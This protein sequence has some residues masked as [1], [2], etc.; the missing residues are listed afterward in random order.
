MQQQ[1]APSVIPHLIRIVCTASI[2]LTVQAIQAQKKPLDHSVYDG[3]QSIGERMI[4]SDGKRVAYTVMPQEGDGE[5]IVQQP[6]SGFRKSIARGYNAAFTFDDSFLIGKIKPLFQDTRQAKIKKKKPDEMPKDTLFILA[7]GTDSL[8]KIARVKEYKLP[9]KGK[10]Y[11]AYLLEK[12]LP[13]SSKKRKPSDSLNSRKEGLKAM[14]DS[15]IGKTIDSVKG[16]ITREE[17][18][19][20]L[21][22]TTE[23]ILKKVR[24][25]E[26][27]DAEGD[28]AA[29]K[30]EA[31]GGTLIVRN[32]FTGRDTAFARIK[33]YW[34]DKYG[35]SL[36]LKTSR[37][38]KDS[39]SRSALLL[40]HLAIRRT[41]TL[42]SAINDAR[43]VA[44][45]ESGV[46]VCFAAERDSSEKALTRFYK[47]WYYRHGYDSARLIADKNTPGM[48]I[49]S[50]VSEHGRIFFSK[51]GNRIFFGTAPVQPPKDT[52]LV[53][54]ETARLDIWHHK[55]EY[56]QT[57]QLKNLDAELK[58]SYTAVYHT[59]SGQLVQAGTE[60]TEL[61]SV[62]D[63][64]NSPWVLLQTN[65][66]YRIASQWTGRSRTDASVMNTENGFMLPVFKG[67]YASATA[68]PGGK[69][70]CWY[71]PEK[72]HYFS[73]D[74]SANKTTNITQKINTPLHDEENDVPDFP[75]PYGLM[76]WQAG[77]SFLY[78]YDR[79]DI[80]KVAPDG[81]FAPQR[82]S[83]K[84]S[85][86]QAQSGR[87]KQ[88][89]TRFINTDK[90]FRFF[91]SGKKY[92]FSGFYED[93]KASSLFLS[94]PDMRNPLFVID[95]EP[96]SNG[97][98]LLSANGEG[99]VFSRESYGLSPE[100]YYVNDKNVV[101]GVEK[102]SPRPVLLTRT[103]PQQAGYN[104][105][106]A[107]LFRWTAYNGKA[108]TGILYK[109][110]DYRPGKHYPMICYFYER[111]SDGLHSYQP[112]APTPS[113]LNISFFV[114]RGYMVFVPDIVY[115]KGH[116]GDDAYDYVASGARALVKKGY[117]DSSRIGI[118]GQSWGGYQVA[119]L[120]TRTPLF[121]AAWAG[122]PV[123][124]M[125]SA[126]GG[127]RWESGLNRQFQYEKQQSR[128]GAA[129]WERPEL[130]INS[131][132]LFKLNKVTTPLAIMHNDADG[133]V[134]WYQG[135]ELFTALRRL[136]K[137]VWMLNY[138]GEAHNLMERRNR[139]DIQ[140]REQQFF[141]WLLKN[142]KPARW[143]SEGVPAL[144]K[145]K[146]WGL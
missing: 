18:A 78:V 29:A 31:E 77:D 107:E 63:E 81:S 79:F 50:T 48:R 145:G 127:I 84:A 114:S 70:I 24:D 115:D 51:D 64:G 61:V 134:P 122:A 132:P 80:W 14:A 90:E 54:F 124:N 60:Q 128:I 26:Q 17:L 46:Q 69:Y 118:Q 97:R 119:Y 111:L 141:D 135:I 42:L 126:Y 110:E 11:L 52:T 123:A 37:K 130:Y 22:T 109:P 91:N 62:L 76:G 59:G 73:Y 74:L 120:I 67:V 2:L 105:G 86:K 6:Q 102:S 72:Q 38:P 13:D 16:K 23:S 40:Y 117:A 19:G 30:S 112:P 99:L 9:E 92:L 140:I 35:T 20:I 103:N 5:L 8:I 39:S 45:D 131:S 144:Y 137:P 89:V 34:F 98:H 138:N 113:R 101:P 143:L 146:D 125:T 21:Q 121:A 96:V 55:D 88:L 32:L 53:E 49:G 33:D 58:R 57:V 129:L 56:L 36:V 71:D 133:A 65:K 108:A 7:T 10:G 82:I 93:S 4:T 47:L 75:A 87:S 66:P 94:S 142:E 85:D 1:T 68:S 43:N 15:I 139:K 106:T 136:G 95:R 44:F 27:T 41:D 12:E 104:W 25:D 3:W 28:D 116:P 83:E 100:L